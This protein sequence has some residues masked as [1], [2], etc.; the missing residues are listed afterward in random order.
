MINKDNEND[1]DIIRYINA[2][3]ETAFYVI[4]FFHL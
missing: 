2:V 3:W 4:N 1:G